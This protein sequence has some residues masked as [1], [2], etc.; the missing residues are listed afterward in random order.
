MNE[1]IISSN[2]IILQSIVCDEVLKN[3]QR[4]NIE[5]YNIVATKTDISC[6]EQVERILN[7][8]KMNKMALMH[9]LA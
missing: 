4:D 1:C 6:I 9:D 7:L 8:I 2:A 5:I 3:P